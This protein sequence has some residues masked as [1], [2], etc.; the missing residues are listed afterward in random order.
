MLH[1][2]TKGNKNMKS[3]TSHK[4]LVGAALLALT[5]CG[6]DNNTPSPDPEPV[7]V[8]PTVSVDNTTTLEGAAISITA[9]GQDSDGSIA[10]YAWTQKS[11]TSVELAGSDTAAVS[12]TAPAVVADETLEFTVTVTDD[13]GATA[14]TD[15]TVSVT[16]NI[17]NL[18]LQG[19]VT[20]SR[21]KNANVEVLLGDQSFETI[22]DE[23]GGYNILIEVDDSYAD[24]MVMIKALGDSEL[25]PEVEFMSQLAPL[26]T[27]IKEAGDDKT[28]N[29]I[30]NFG[31]N[32]TNLTTAD[33]ALV[34]QKSETS[35]KT[36][37]N[38]EAVDEDKKLLLSALIKIVVDGKG[39][40]AYELPGGVTSTLDLV[41]D[42]ATA[43]AFELQVN[44]DN[45]D[46][47]AEVTNTIINDPSVVSNDGIVGTWNIDDNQNEQGSIITFTASGYVIFI[48]TENDDEGYP[49]FELGTYEW[50][51]NTGSLTVTIHEDT[52]GGVG[53]YDETDET[54]LGQPNLIDQPFI[55]TGNILTIGTPDNGGT[56][57]RLISDS[58][59][60]VGGYITGS[61][62]HSYFWHQIFVDDNHEITLLHTGAIGVNAATYNWDNTTGIFTPDTFSVS[63]LGESFEEEIF[64][65]VGD[66]LLYKDGDYTTVLKRTHANSDQLYLTKKDVTGSYSG[67]NFSDEGEGAFQI[68][69]NDDFT[70]QLTIENGDIDLAWFINK[71]QLV[72][73]LTLDGNEVIIIESATSISDKELKFSTSNFKLLHNDG[74]NETDLF[75]Y[76]TETWTR[77]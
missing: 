49:G 62:E 75:E 21:I 34:L 8:A 53:F 35:N 45:P 77:N 15:V 29:K 60:L 46:L 18:T 58:N 7:N 70:G 67:I 12:F 42:S 16:A 47:I 28:L 52:N 59:P 4:L 48:K 63:Q 39:D 64:K 38:K 37:V 36:T 54:E 32:V 66:R 17:L 43:D 50:D 71:G 51:K 24:E 11:G 55:V 31:V 2:R 1:N 26:N 33:Y 3:K 69:L 14:A 13:D 23:Q 65:P 68:V 27:L 22:A 44:A 10:S 76:T 74:G 30:E 9:S 5:A 56:W 57:H 6:S 20:D 40:D 72:L 73:K 61:L 25:Q 41:D 19:I